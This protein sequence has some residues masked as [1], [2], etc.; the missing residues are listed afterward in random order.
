MQLLEYEG[1]E[2]A[3]KYGIPFPKG[4][5]AKN[6]EEVE[7]ALKKLNGK[8]VLKAQI[9]GTGRKKAGGIFFVNSINEGLEVAKNLF[10]REILGQKVNEIL[11][12]E[13]V[14]VKREFYIGFLINSEKFSYTLIASKYGGINVEEVHDVLKLEIDPLT[15]LQDFMIRDT[16]NYLEIH[17]KSTALQLS[18]IIRNLYKIFLEYDC[19]FIEVNPLALTNDGRLVALDIKLSID[20]NALF[21]HKDLTEI[22]K[23]RLTPN[24]IIALKYGFSYVEL[25][26]DIGVIG[27]GAG[28]TMATMD[29]LMLSGGKPAFF[30]DIGGGAKAERVKE[31]LKLALNNPHVKA[32]LMNILGGITRCDEVAKGIIQAIEES[33]IKKPIVV[34]LSGTKEE[35]GRRI[36]ESKGIKYFTNMEDAIKEIIKLV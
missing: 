7:S 14:N 29:I 3:E 12:C 5:L 4:Y 8:G 22:F 20:D 25:D 19:E 33:N 27:N 35:E 31:A 32:I 34:R 30:L 11:V 13:R 21:R 24:E 2:I 28:L 17:D 23:K 18:S 26:G 6:L 9:K 16:I 10:G 1:R 15:S 36:L